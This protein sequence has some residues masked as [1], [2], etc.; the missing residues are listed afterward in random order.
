MPD[1]LIWAY[2]AILAV[3]VT[4]HTPSVYLPPQ[5]NFILQRIVQKQNA[6]FNFLK[7]DTNLQAHRSATATFHVI[8][9]YS[10]RG[11]VPSR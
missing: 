11:V 6:I 3:L 7:K 10:Q 5:L 9:M 2:K 4:A 8:H 1:S